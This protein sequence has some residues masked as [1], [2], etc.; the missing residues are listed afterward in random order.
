MQVEGA[1]RTV[2]QLF[3]KTSPGYLFTAE[4]E[5]LSDAVLEELGRLC[6]G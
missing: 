5:E 3:V 2:L 1:L 6:F 4:T